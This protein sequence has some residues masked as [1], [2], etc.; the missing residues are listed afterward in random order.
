MW[1]GFMCIVSDRII[2]SVVSEANKAK[3]L[4]GLVSHKYRGNW[5]C[6]QTLTEHDV[7]IMQHN[8]T[9]QYSV[10]IIDA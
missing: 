2:V 5:L 8:I 1:V 7:Y 6:I 3:C 9:T 4:H 10:L